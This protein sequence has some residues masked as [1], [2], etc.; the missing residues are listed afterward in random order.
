MRYSTVALN[1]AKRNSILR[2]PLPQE[3]ALSETEELE[4]FQQQVTEIRTGL[5]LPQNIRIVCEGGQFQLLAQ[6]LD[7]FFF[8]VNHEAAP[9]F[10][11][12]A[13]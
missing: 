6:K 2:A 12:R 9:P 10:P 13:S 8:G 5:A 7:L 1:W 4:K 11:Q 3:H